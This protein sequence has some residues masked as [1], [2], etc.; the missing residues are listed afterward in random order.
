M[1]VYASIQYRCTQHIH[2]V[3]VYKIHTGG[4]HEV[5]VSSSLKGADCSSAYDNDHHRRSANDSYRIETTIRL[6]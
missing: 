1:L 4:T 6:I 5:P 2:A 3:Q